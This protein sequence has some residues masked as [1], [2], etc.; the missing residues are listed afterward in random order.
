MGIKIITRVRETVVQ[1]HLGLGRGIDCGYLG[2]GY[3]DGDYKGSRG[4]FL[5][6]KK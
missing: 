3:L 6:N 1:V 2:G 4:G 5:K